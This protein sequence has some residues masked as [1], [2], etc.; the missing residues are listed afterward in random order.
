MQIGVTH[1]IQEGSQILVDAWIAALLTA[2]VVWNRSMSQ[3]DVISMKI[4]KV[5]YALDRDMADA[6]DAAYRAGGDETVVRF[7]HDHQAMERGTR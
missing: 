3:G 4:A 2:H 6:L 1:F 5:K 7:V